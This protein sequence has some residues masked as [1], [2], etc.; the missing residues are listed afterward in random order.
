MECRRAMLVLGTREVFEG[1]LAK[2]WWCFLD[3]EGADGSM[4]APRPCVL[5]CVIARHRVKHGLLR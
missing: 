4:C 5:L 2:L 1:M 3:G